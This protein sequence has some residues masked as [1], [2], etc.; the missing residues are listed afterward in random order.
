M[1]RLR[2][3]TNAQDGLI[4]AEQC[5]RIGISADDVKYW[6]RGKRWRAVTRGVY[7]VDADLVGDEALTTRRLIRAGHLALGPR[8]VVTLASAAHL[9]GIEG[10]R[11]EAKT[12]IHLS[13]NGPDARPRRL[14]TG[15]LVPHQFVFRPADVVELE[16]MR[17]TSAVRTVADLMLTSRRYEAI[18]ILDNALNGRRVTEEELCRLEQLMYRR[19][20]A[21]KARP[22]IGLA[23]GRAESPLETRV[24]LRCKDGGVPPDELQALIMGKDGQVIARTDML[25]SRHKLVGEADGEDIHGTPSAL[26]NDRT[27]QNALAAAGFT[28]IRFT[29]KDTVDPDRIP[30]I[31]RA[32]MRRRSR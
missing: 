3:L 8:S 13:L 16:G 12:Q 17:V 9:H 14:G 30:R 7:L 22:W 31:V 4:T 10:L 26:F 24:R 23:D 20:G 15:T 28:V 32:A 1:N 11:P 18:S 27:R 19:R 6:V 5:G 2:Q 25:W 29:W 21:R